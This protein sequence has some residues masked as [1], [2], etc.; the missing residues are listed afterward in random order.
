MLRHPHSVLTPCS[1]VKTL[2][3]RQTCSPCI[4]TCP[5][6]V[7]V[8]AET[9]WG[10]GKEWDELACNQKQPQFAIP[11]F[12]FFLND[13][14]IFIWV[15]VVISLSHVQLLIHKI[16]STLAIFSAWI[17]V[18]ICKTSFAYNCVFLVLFLHCNTHLKTWL[19][20]IVFLVW[21][22]WKSVQHIALC[23]FIIWNRLPTT[24]CVYLICLK[25][26]V[27]QIFTSWS[28]SIYPNGL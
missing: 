3:S 19:L 8:R 15:W 6:L 28:Y 13:K 21:K 23:H 14:L 11:S 5:F 18:V 10:I 22:L 27:S 7:T 2:S 9:H 1:C 12:S 20:R 25:N 24:I 4:I 16:L 26:R 17:H